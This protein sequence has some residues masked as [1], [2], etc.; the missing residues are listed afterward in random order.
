M[1]LPPYPATTK[2]GGFKFELDC[3]RIAQSDT[4]ALATV[5]QRPLLLMLWFIAW[6]QTPCGSLPADDVLIA[7]RLGMEADAF[8][9]DRAILLR[10]WWEASDGRLYHPVLTELVLEMMGRK[11][12]NAQRQAAYRQRRQ[13]VSRDGQANDKR[14]TNEVVT[15]Y[16][17]VSD[18]TTTTTTTTNESIPDGIDAAR[19]RKSP[20][21]LGV[22]DLVA[23]GVEQQHAE[24]WLTVRKA[25]RA[26][27]TRAAWDDLKAEAT[28]AGITPADAVKVS[29]TNSWQGF[30]ATWY[31]K[32]GQEGSA[33]R[34]P[35]ATGSLKTNGTHTNITH[36]EGSHCRNYGTGGL[37]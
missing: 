20:K 35:A 17:G 16:S 27:L 33:A 21:T 11:A 34:G 31:A 9:H 12:S 32:L 36:R 28:K 29:A 19:T 23:E 37:L 10:G 30:K 25:K 22:S 8:Q 3:E 6:Q 13:G 1:Q 14:E 18:N 15:R 24:D 7:A 26:P 4:W 2:A 5:R